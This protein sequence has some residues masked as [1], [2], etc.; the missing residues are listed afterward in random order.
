MSE[1]GGRDSVAEKSDGRTGG[2]S[3]WLVF[4][5]IAADDESE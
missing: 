4:A 2:G 1:E 5:A 3:G